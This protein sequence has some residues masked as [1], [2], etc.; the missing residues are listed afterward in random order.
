[1]NLDSLLGRPTA[2][3]HDSIIERIEVDYL[4]REAIIHLQI[5]TG[6]PYASAH[7]ERERKDPGRLTI[8]GLLYLVVEPPDETYPFQSD[9]GLWIKDD[10]ITSQTPGVSARLPWDL[11]PGAFVHRF[12][13]DDWNSFIYVAGTHAK[14]SW[15]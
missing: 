11:P 10:E 4:K 8:S 5:E 1:M 12:F 13:V 9:E 7:A 15:K 3:F 2:T 6:N 14:F